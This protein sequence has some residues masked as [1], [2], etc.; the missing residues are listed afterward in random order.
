CKRLFAL[1]LVLL[2][3]A[4]ADAADELRVT[5]HLLALYTFDSGEGDVVRDRS[6]AGHP[7]DL[8]IAEQS[9]VQWQ[10]G[11]LVVQSPAMIRSPG[12]AK[13]II[14]H[15]KHSRAMTI[16]A[17]VTP[18]I[19]K[20]SGPARIVSLS[21]NTGE[22][23]F[24]LGQEGKQ[25]DVRFRSTGTNTNGLPSIATSSDTATVSLRHVVYTRDPSGAAQI[26]IDG[27]Q[28]STG[29]V[30]GDLS[31]W[32]NDYPFVLAN[33]VT[34]DRPWIGTI[35]L[36][37]IYSRALTAKE[38]KQN[39]QAG[40]D[41][42][43]PPAFAE[44]Q[45]ARQF[46]TK[47]AGLFA[48]NCL[49][50]HD[51]A[52]REGGLDLSRKVAALEGGDSGKA[53]IPGNSAESLLWEQVDSN[54]MPPEGDPL[55]TLDKA[56]LRQWI[57]SGAVWSLDLIDPV[58]YAHSGGARDI[59]L[60]RLTVSEYIETVRS[61]VGVDIA[62]EARDLLPPDL[63]ADGFSNTAYN[64]NV[65]LKHVQAYA[66]L[67]EIIVERMDVLKFAAKFS[68][69]QSLSTDDTMR[70]FVAALGK[71]LLR[72]PLEERE[73]TNY[74]GIATTVASAGGNFE[75]AVILI[76]E[77]MLQSPRFVYRVEQQ[78]GDGMVWPV[79]DYELAS[80]L[81]YIIWG[82]PPDDEL[83]RA[84]GAGELQDRSNIK[85]QVGRMLKNPRAIQRSKQFIVEWL[86]LDRLNNLQPDPER[87]PNWDAALAADMR[88][89]TLAFFEE[90]VW[91]QDRPLADLLNAQFTY[92][93]PRLAAHYGLEPEGT[94]LARYNLASVPARGG[95][96]TQGSVL[97]IGGD[98]ASMVTR[99]LFILHDLLR[100]TVNDPPPG[101]DTTPVPSKPG[102][103]H[104][105]ISEVRIADN[106]CGGC[107]VRFEPL[108]FGL[109]K[110][111]GLG[112]FREIDEHGNEL[113]EN[114]E[115]F[116]PGAA[117]PIKYRSS[118]E[119]MDLLARGD[120]VRETFTWLVTQF[121]LGRPLGAADVRNMK[122]IHESAQNGGGTYTSLIT[123]IVTSDLV[124]MTH[125][126]AE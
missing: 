68:K 27:Q 79:G 14:D 109:E 19:D 102:M 41:A 125:T 28:Q 110:F 40:A 72:G 121:A 67:A 101:L 60:Q 117:E 99:G 112:A 93:T 46:E 37:A 32:H 113:R 94:G 107:H 12:P 26:Y 108:A 48:R 16:E 29:E 24:T 23:N 11:A 82:G 51:S 17:W 115:I 7:L 50:C 53:I 39:F 118:A 70:E 104:R 97:T 78:R 116:F 36:V 106:A 75:E 21:A 13:K 9:A 120:R 59:W 42:A 64:L 34:G 8:K 89:E 80:R 15:I 114:G 76:I 54:S 96:L 45:R 61:S 100:G 5:R 73:I 92:A 122:D 56:L 43:A 1:C 87:F 91:K 30:S 3:L 33:E 111:N 86:D 85:S 81:S 62:K 124:M 6:G 126:Q 44:E 83:M 123:A 71:R 57:D 77:A 63:R 88:E 90:V 2:S 119:L 58:I 22:R 95:L 66:R 38:I 4:A 98:D 20:Q 10:D 55:S 103:S 69:S 105:S 52:A 74:S 47:I 25:F 18:E 49:E 31:N 35:Q 65:D 84:A